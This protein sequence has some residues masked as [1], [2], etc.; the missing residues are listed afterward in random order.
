MRDKLKDDPT[1]LTDYEIIEMLLTQVLPRRDT[2][3]LAKELLKRF[4]SI[5][6]VLEARPSELRQ[7]K[8][9]GPALEAHWILLRELMS[10]RE[11]SQA[12]QRQVLT[13]SAL[14]AH[15]ARTRL[16]GGE[17]EELWTAFVDSHNRLISWEKAN[18]GTVAGITCYPRELFERAIILK[19][20]GIIM[21]HNHPGGS[22]TPSLEDL[23]L[24]K[25]IAE[26]AKQIGLRLI[27][28]I[29][30]TDE[31]HYSLSDDDLF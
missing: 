6:G 16:A 21:A 31:G 3:P 1:K 23:D 2:K 9:F 26:S 7:V 14:V 19:A 29:I 28:H 15:M 4:Q 24:T 25:H 22:L 10:R 27:D 30:V 5:K 13:N 18:Q 17:K 11:E 20:S 12:R 8:G